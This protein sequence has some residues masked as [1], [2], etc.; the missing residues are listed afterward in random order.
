MLKNV[1][2]VIYP[3][4]KQQVI[5]INPKVIDHRFL[6]INNEFIVRSFFI[7]RVLFD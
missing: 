2:K 4:N 5:E 7:N 1:E 6:I 3:T